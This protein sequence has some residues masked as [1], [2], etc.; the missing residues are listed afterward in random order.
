MNTK[1]KSAKTLK[2]VTTA[3]RNREDFRF[4][5]MRGFNAKAPVSAGYSQ[6]FSKKVNE[7]INNLKNV[8]VIY[9]YGTPIAA[10]IDGE[11]VVTDE[12]FSVTTSRHTNLAK[13]AL[14][15]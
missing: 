9:S 15:Y 14:N 10:E 11:A 12:K 8:Y 13:Q 1:S 5:T 6:E 7:A 2:D 4:N 3:I